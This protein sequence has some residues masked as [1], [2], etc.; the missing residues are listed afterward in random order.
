MSEPE[1]F[2]SGGLE[3][4]PD[5]NEY[6]SEANDVAIQENELLTKSAFQS[7]CKDSENFDIDVKAFFQTSCSKI[8]NLVDENSWK[9]EITKYSSEGRANSSENVLNWWKRHETVFPMFKMARNFIAISATSASIERILLRASL[10]DFN[11]K[12]KKKI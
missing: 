3:F 2:Q 9:Y 12:I 10:T 1:P 7:Q 4:I 6:D 5:E 11:I 8:A